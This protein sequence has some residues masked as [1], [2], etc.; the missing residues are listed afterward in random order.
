MAAPQALRLPADFFTSF[1]P[2]PSEYQDHFAILY[3]KLF[4]NPMD[5]IYGLGM[6]TRSFSSQKDMDEYLGKLV[7]DGRWNPD[8]AF[9]PVQTGMPF[10]ITTDEKFSK[11]VQNIET[12]ADGVRKL[13][14]LNDKERQL[15]QQTAKEIR[16]KI[17]ELKHE[18]QTEVPGETPI[19][20]TADH[21]SLEYYTMQRVKA[22]YLANFLKKIDERKRDATSGLKKAM[23]EIERLDETH[24]DYV[25]QWAELHRAEMKKQGLPDSAAMFGPSITFD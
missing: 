25:N 10:M 15:K 2:M 13:A 6:V 9:L 21:E 3:V 19:A 20:N 16:E 7:T 23:L 18:G 4:P 11:E 22:T 14:Q 24:S 1:K 8:G 17:D 5:G 12:D